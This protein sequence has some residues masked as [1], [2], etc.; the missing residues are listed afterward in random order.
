MKSGRYNVYLS[1]KKTT[2]YKSPNK[3]IRRYFSM[4]YSHFAALTAW[5]IPNKKDRHR[6]RDLCKEIDTKKET[7]IIQQRYGNIVQKLKEKKVKKVLFLINENSKW[8]AQSL[9]DLMEQSEDFEPVIAV[10][11]ADVQRKLTKEEK[12]KFIEDNVKFFQDK[13]M[14]VVTAFNSDKNKACDLRKFNPDIVFYQQPYFISKIQDINNVSKFALTC[15]I[16]YFLSSRENY[17]LE[18]ELAFHRKLFRFYVWN[19]E[20]KNDFKKVLDEKELYSENMRA[21]G[22]TM[23]DYFYLNKDKKRTANYVIYAPHWAIYNKLNENHINCSTF[24]KTGKII[25]DYAKKHKKLNWVFKPHPTL[26]A[27]LRRIGMTEIEI[28]SYYGDWESFAACCYDSSYIDLFF[29]SKALITDCGSFLI[30]YFCTGNPIINLINPHCTMKPYDFL[31][32][33][34]ETFYTVQDYEKELNN[35]LDEILINGVDTKK[36]ER[37]NLFAKYKFNS[38]YAALNILNDLRNS[39]KDTTGRMADE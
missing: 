2:G 12:R 7:K 9:Y 19:N 24:D 26:K 39:I 11:S 16:P 6:F 3:N 21:A 23:L 1:E 22:H 8:K 27:V 37:E 18:C 33:M 36:H 25:L 38:E 15:Y 13:K 32:P 20:L 17:R 4:K 10:T 28:N 35:I 14:H 29:N 34:F 31:R 5:I 30:E